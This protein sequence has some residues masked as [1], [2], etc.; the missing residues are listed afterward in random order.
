MMEKLTEP[1]MLIRKT[2]RVEKRLLYQIEVVVLTFTLSIIDITALI[3][4][5]RLK[6]THKEY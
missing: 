1:A 3:L 5:P 4:L 2:G 6:E